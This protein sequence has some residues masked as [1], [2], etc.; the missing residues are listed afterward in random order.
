MYSIY[1]YLYYDEQL[2]KYSIYRI[3]NLPVCAHGRRVI[4]AWGCL[5]PP[6][7]IKVSLA[8]INDIF[9]LPLY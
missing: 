6:P 7:Q 4:R 2:T 3:V 8:K 1:S 5:S 9:H